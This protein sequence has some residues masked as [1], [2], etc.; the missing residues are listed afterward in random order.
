MT[1]TATF[2]LMSVH[3]RSAVDSPAEQ[4]AA[5]RQVRFSEPVANPEIDASDEDEGVHTAPP[6]SAHPALRAG[7]SRID[8]GLRRGRGRPD[9]R[10]DRQR[11]EAYSLAHVRCLSGRL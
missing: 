1:L 2:Q 9:D 11:R 3:K 6:F 5:K 10:G 8:V 7:A 4:P